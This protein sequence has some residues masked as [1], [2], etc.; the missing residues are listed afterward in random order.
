MNYDLKR[1]AFSVAVMLLASSNEAFSQN[2][3]SL[4]HIRT[5]QI[6]HHES[7][8][9]TDKLLH[10]AGSPPQAVV[11]SIS[12]NTISFPTYLGNDNAQREQRLNLRLKPHYP[13]ISSISFNSD[14]SVV[15]FYCNEKLT[16]EMITELVSHFGYIGYVSK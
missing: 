11:T 5:V 16:G 8:R 4:Q 10:A 7:T 3:D 15:T 1:L 14:F 12:T 13:Y 2:I 6:E 9:E